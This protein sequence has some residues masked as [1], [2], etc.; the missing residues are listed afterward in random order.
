VEKQKN[1]SRILQN[2]PKK[3]L[4]G[5]QNELNKPNNTINWLRN[6]ETRRNINK[7]AENTTKLLN[8]TTP[9]KKQTEPI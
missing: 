6:H 7:P 1:W 2:L 4:I 8:F 5:Q 9:T 3:H